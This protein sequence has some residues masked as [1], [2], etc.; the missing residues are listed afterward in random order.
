LQDAEFKL[1]LCLEVRD[2]TVCFRDVYDLMEWT[3]DCPAPQKIEVADGFY[4]V[5]VYSSTPDSG[6]IGQD[7]TIYLHFERVAAKPAVKWDGVPQLC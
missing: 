3:A 7:Q 1:R 5:T 6:I 4:S 2:G